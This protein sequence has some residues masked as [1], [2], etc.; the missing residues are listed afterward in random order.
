MAIG[1]L[2][3]FYSKVEDTMM[4]ENLSKFTIVSIQFL[5][6]FTL[7]FVKTEPKDNAIC[8]INYNMKWI[9]SCIPNHL[10]PFFIYINNILF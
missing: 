4:Q 1:L 8:I 7:D 3:F 9:C 10:S 5:F 6:S 2:S